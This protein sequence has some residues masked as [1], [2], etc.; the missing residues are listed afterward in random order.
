MVMTADS[1]PLTAPTPS[2]S[3]SLRAHV[4]RGQLDLLYKQTPI[5]LT[6][7][8]L[9]AILMC[10]AMW[11]VFPHRLVLVWTL[12]I[13]CASSL[14]RGFTAVFACKSKRPRRMQICFNLFLLGTFFSGLGWGFAGA[15]FI[16][17]PDLIHRSFVVF[18]LLG[19]TAAASPFYSA[20]VR[21]YLLFLLPA[22]L[23]FTVWLFLQGGDNLYLGFGGILYIIVMLTASFYSSRLLRRTLEL[24][25]EV[26]DL[27]SDNRILEQ[28]V[29]DRTA[30]L[31]KALDF[32]Q[33]TL[34][35]TTDGIIMIDSSG[36]VAYSNQMFVTLWRLSRQQ[37]TGQPYDL[38]VQRM[39]RQLKNSDEFIDSFRN[40]TRN[41]DSETGIELNFIDGKVFECYSRPHWRNGMVAG[42]VWSFRDVTARNKLTHRANHDQLTDLPNR[43]L[44]YDRIEQGIVFSRR[45]HSN[46]SLLFI[47][48]D[49]FKI[50][51]DTL[52]HN[53]GDMLL[54]EIAGRLKDCTR[55]SDTV[56]R[57]GGD[58]FVIL[59]MESEQTGVLQLSH[60]ILKRISEPVM[61]PSQELTITA[62]I[63][64]SMYP[65][66]GDNAMSLLKNA[67]MAMYMAKKR[68]RNNFQFYNELIYQQSVERLKI[69]TELYDA[70]LNNEFFIEYQPILSLKNMT[71]SG[72]E[73]LV[74]WH[75][76]N[77]GTI[78]PAEF[79][80]IAENN[81]L[82]NQ[83][84]AWIFR[85]SCQ[86]I[87][88]WRDQG[89]NI[90]MAINISC[91]QMKGDS[92]IDVVEKAVQ[93]FQ[94]DPQHL[95]LEF[96]EKAIMENIDQIR[97]TLS[98]F[99]KMG[100][101][102]AI[103]DFGI[104]YSSMNY[105]KAFPINKLKIDR[106][107]IRECTN[108]AD[109]AA[110]VKAIIA[111]GKS[112][113]LKV[114]AEGVETTEQLHFL[115]DNQCDEAQG[116]LFSKAIRG[117]AFPDL[118]KQDFAALLKGR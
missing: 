37:I 53:S 102:M 91:V 62:S 86:Q 78:Y 108:D 60:T 55:D 111:M 51:N 4:F 14:L 19:V 109:N 16:N 84:G 44:F 12:F 39:S 23:P 63:G 77:H 82:I 42:Q 101:Q 114:L 116:N 18:I 43:A 3:A 35:S 46:M 56:A 36:K 105:L 110:A 104:G 45:R 74:R 9:V 11:D 97:A 79:I 107:F 57:F 115:C 95:E 29:A 58:E 48:L 21:V 20:M 67:D 81:G 113:G 7:E 96:T 33:S 118:I 26:R 65:K 106:S 90:G 32:T 89:L 71:I 54:K 99:N 87:Q 8:G 61:L 64:I 6:A 38:V 49:D 15:V 30:A 47:D 52:G 59:L 68:G 80:S 13:I 76:P 5:T 69:Q 92:F 66:D 31:E 22:M 93:D 98:R 40:I 28:K 94:I 24:Q 73:A 85:E 2:R 1:V 34:E 50:I 17:A 41:P 27:G 75:H 10:L 72:A 112:L 103:D 83:L 25:Y 70:L 100:I 117:D 88:Q